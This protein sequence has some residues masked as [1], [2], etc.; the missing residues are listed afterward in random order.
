MPNHASHGN[1]S[2]RIDAMLDR[3]GYSPE[4]REII[5]RENL[6]PAGLLDRL[7][8]EFP[9][10]SGFREE[11]PFLFTGK[12]VYA[13]L[14]GFREIVAIL[15]GHGIRIGHIA[16]RELFAEIYRFMAT[17][18]ALNVINW[19]KF[20]TDSMFQLI[21]PQPGMFRDTTLVDAYQKASADER[22]AIVRRYIEEHT[23]PHDGKQLL[24]KPWYRTDSG[25][26]VLIKGS[27]H[28]YPPCQ[29]IFDQATQNCFAFCT[30]CFRHAQVRGDEDMFLQKN[31]DE[32]HAYL[33]EHKEVSD[34]LITG[35]DA[36]FIPHDRFAA[37]VTPMMTDPALRHIRTVRL[38][39]RIMSYSPERLLTRAYEPMLDLFGRLADHGIRV[40]F[41]MHFSTPREVLNPSTVAAIR[42]LERRHVCLKSQSPI[43]RHISLFT[44]P[45]G[46]VDVE[47]S[48]R[49]WIDLGHI[50]GMLN[51]GFHS[52]YCARST[53][54]YHYFN[55]PLADIDRIFSRIYRELPSV[56]R[57][58]R[59]ITQTSSAGKISL[60][61]TAE[62]AG[63]KV[64]A[65]KFNEGRNME[66]MDRVFFARYDEETTAIDRLK[67]F[68]AEKFFFEGELVE[69]EERLHNEISAAL[70]A[71][72]AAKA[73]RGDTDGA[74][75]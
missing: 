27:Q 16:E 72:R 31:I 8:E 52:M 2:T 75:Q 1:H 56:S 59:Y 10:H 54:E 25:H 13:G 37:Y 21:F 74:D 9:Q 15:E 50:L 41:N 68:G 14:A 35:G 30:Y 43:M 40:L 11:A 67:P 71:E 46:K 7:H 22:Q 53:G 33:R 17:R 55:A 24:N 5:A 34:I 18:H 51:I 69:I 12:D 73:G 29:L 49:N 42:R 32:I 45:D 44:T 20:A 47:R 57:P 23:N 26:V 58:S 38:G 61:G 63:E 3:Y 4:T 66:W 64:F 36:G 62:I 70:K 6:L 60:L 39:T 48:A 19:S 28:K 65:L